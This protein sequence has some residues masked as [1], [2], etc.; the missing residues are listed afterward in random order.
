MRKV[1]FLLACMMFPL[2]SWAN[3]NVRGVVI[4]ASDREPVIGA[5]VLEVGTS[6]GTITDIDG[7]YELTVG[8]NA[9]LEVSYV[10]LK[11]Q[12]IKVTGPQMNVVMQDDAI[13]VEEV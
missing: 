3:V 6:N 7:A 2:M 1:Y 8:D 13:A 9:T 4:Q 11:T 5:S 12:R 10:G